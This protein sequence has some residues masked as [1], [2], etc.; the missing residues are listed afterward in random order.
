MQDK[1]KKIFVESAEVKK[2]AAD[3]IVAEIE[4]AVKMIIVAIK[5]GHKILIFGNGGSAADAQHFTGEFVNKFKIE[6]DPL[7]AMALHPDTSVLTAIA[8]DDGYHDTF[9]K[10]VTAFGQEG[11]VAIAITTSDVEL[12]K[13]GHSANIAYALQEARNKKMKTIGLLSD[14]SVDVV[15]MVD[16]AIKAPSKDTPRIQ[17][18]HETI[19]HIICELAEEELK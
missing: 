18:C 7:P 10:W 16:L 13:D 6:R 15:D 11:D 14:K 4:A 8:N 19:L 1:I 5:A 9:R 17:E 3:T 2:K 12:K